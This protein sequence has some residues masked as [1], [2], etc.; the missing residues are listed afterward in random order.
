MPRSIPCLPKQRGERRLTSW[1]PQ[2]RFTL[3]LSFSTLI[4]VLFP[5]SSCSASFCFKLMPGILA[6]R[7]LTSRLLI[8][9]QF[10]ACVSQSVTTLLLRLF[11]AGNIRDGTGR[12][13]V[14]MFGGKK[15][16]DGTGRDGKVQW[17]F[18][19]MTGRDGKQKLPRR[20]GT[21]N[22][23]CHDGTERYI[24]FCS[25]GRDGA[26]NFPR[27]DGMVYY[28]FHDEKGRYF[29]VFSTARAVNFVFTTGR[30]TVRIFFH[31][32]TGWRNEE[33]TVLSIKAAVIQVKSYT[34][35]I[36]YRHTISYVHYQWV[37]ICTE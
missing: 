28:F 3:N 24:F 31:C 15:V 14:D 34:P 33:H 18:G 29:F 25:T 1:Y 16:E 27:R 10:R 2:Y 8:C 17:P 32:C 36:S 35:Y 22:K 19:L 20:D 37:L 13:C 6:S 5:I 7:L 9:D 23:N 12:Y 26:C 30:G 4:S 21:V 11:M